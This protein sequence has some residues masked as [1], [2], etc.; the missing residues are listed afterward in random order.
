MNEDG[1]QDPRLEVA[2]LRQDNL[3]YVALLGTGL[4]W[5]QAFLATTSL[6]LSAKI[7]IVAWAVAIPLLAAL[8]L[9]NSQESFRRRR[10]RSNLAILGKAVGQ[11]AA[12]IGF[13]AGFWHIWWPAG[14]VVLAASVAGVFIHSAGFYR[15]EHQSP[16]VPPDADDSAPD[17]PEDNS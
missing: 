10:S 9:L 17:E 6:D 2:W 7:C 4:L 11:L 3:G 1:T 16:P 8:V 12:F 13:A 14:T 5:V 15:L